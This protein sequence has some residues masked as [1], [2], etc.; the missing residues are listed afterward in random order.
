[1]KHI[2]KY[3]L[4]G[5]VALGFTSCNDWLD[6][7]PKTSIPMD[8]QFASESG[9]KDALTGIYLKLG[10]TVLYAGDMSYAYL[11]EMAGQY[12]NYPSHNTNMVYH[13]GFVFDYE[14]EFLDK[15]EGIYSEMYNIV[16]NINNLLEYLEKKRDIVTTEHLYGTMKGEALALRAFVHFDLL[17][18]YGPIYQQH[19]D[20]KAIAYRTVY[21][22]NATSILPAREV[23]QLIIK[24]LKEAEELLKKDDP[25]D[26]RTDRSSEEYEN[27]N[28]FLVNREYRM[29]LYAVKAILAR[30]Y[31]YENSAESRTL[32]VKYANEVINSGK[33]SL[34][35]QQN[36]NKYNS[37]R[38]E[39]QIFGVSVNEM[40]NLLADNGMDMESTSL[41]HHFYTDAE[42]FNQIYEFGGG[43]AGHVGQSDW[44]KDGQA[45]GKD[46]SAEHYFCRKFNQKGMEYYMGV[47][48]MPLIRLPEM[49]YIVAECASSA[50][51]SVKALN[52]V[53]SARGIAIA[54]EITTVGYDAPDNLSKEAP[55]YT[56]RINEIMKEVRKE[57][58]GEGQLFFFL[59]SHA[60]EWY[61]G[62]ELKNMSEAQY[63]MPLP[64]N[65]HVFGKTSD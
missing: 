48:T 35:A 59:K 16:A 10:T 29:N 14:K 3:I 24:D 52:T 32:A 9:F 28:H 38:Y 60:Y 40:G 65:E 13:Q 61:L 42:H 31:C 4:W 58:F 11:E 8:K 15:R 43:D 64:D 62:A 56:K 5:C 45:F 46:D 12:D 2:I 18:L 57:Y 6:V 33:W 25:L 41:N 50:E 1:M 63:K 47:N 37:I 51:E 17:R 21:D 20:A 22:R 39:E 54:D 19:P 26:F 53:R 7:A 30:A 34:L 55:R 49:Y 27:G 44:R 36:L 23:L